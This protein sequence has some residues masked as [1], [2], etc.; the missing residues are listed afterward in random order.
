MISAKTRKA[1][2]GDDIAI[3]N[4]SPDGPYTFSG[5]VIQGNKLGR[6]LGFPTANL[7]IDKAD[8]MLL[9]NGVYVVK[10]TLND[11]GYFGMMNIGFR[12]TVG[13]TARTIEIHFFDFGENL[14]G[15]EIQVEVWHRPRKEYEF[16]SV[17]ALQEQLKKDKD[18]S[19]QLIAK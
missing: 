17:E 7:H 16:N 2:L 12:P 6:Q 1:L 4:L 19:F 5:T 3:A 13:G 8:K 15:T 10:S 9:P 14:Y 18:Q 11:Q